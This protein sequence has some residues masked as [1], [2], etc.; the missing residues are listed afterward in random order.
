MLSRL[1]SVIWG[2]RPQVPHDPHVVDRI[3][4]EVADELEV[5]GV[6]HALSRVTSDLRVS[7]D[8]SLERR[9]DS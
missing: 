6:L 9:H 3:V 2:R 4:E 1:R 7:L 8:L 5:Q